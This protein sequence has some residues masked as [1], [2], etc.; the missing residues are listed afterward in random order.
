MSE[1]LAD[2]SGEPTCDTT[3][4]WATVSFVTVGDANP[5]TCMA[6]T[7]GAYALIFD[8]EGRLIDT[9]LDLFVGFSSKAGWLLSLKYLRWPCLA[10]QTVVYACS[11]PDLGE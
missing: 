7:S 2:S 6:S 4:L 10:G 11:N 9:T 1:D 3:N 5:A 8:D